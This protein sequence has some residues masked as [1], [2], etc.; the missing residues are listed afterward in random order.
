[1]TDPSTDPSMGDSADG[2]SERDPFAPIEASP[3][4][5]TSLAAAGFVLAAA[6][7]LLRLEPIAGPLGMAVG[8]VAHVKGSRLGIPAAIASGVAMIAGMAI[9]MYL[10]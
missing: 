4:F 3:R 1:M 5:A 7:I 6:A 8:V 10:R 2:S 9:S